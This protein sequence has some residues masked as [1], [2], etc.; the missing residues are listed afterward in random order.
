MVCGTP[1]I[2]RFK[3]MVQVAFMHKEKC[4]RLKS[5]ML[6]KVHLRVRRGVAGDYPMLNVLESL[7]ASMMQDARMR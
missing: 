6:Y 7:I 1:H 2:I 5:S 4:K 3:G